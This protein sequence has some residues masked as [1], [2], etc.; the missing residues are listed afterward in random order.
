MNSHKFSYAMELVSVA[1]AININAYLLSREQA[2][3]YI[4]NVL[5]KYRPWKA[6]GH[7]SISDNA[8]RLSTEEYEFSFSLAMENKPA[9]IF[10]EQNY[11]NKNEVVIVENAK[12]ISELMKHSHGMEYF[13]SDK[14]ATYLIAVNWY[15]IEYVGDLDLRSL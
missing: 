12:N 2:E 15:C 5:N 8:D 14:N 1:S 3:K 4:M 7:L 10:F 11:I 13:V 6:T 9:Y